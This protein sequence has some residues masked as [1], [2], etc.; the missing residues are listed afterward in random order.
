MGKIH[1]L[2]SF[3]I[4]YKSS[5]EDF[6]E[7]FSKVPGMVVKWEE[8]YASLQIQMESRLKAYNGQFRVRHITVGTP[9]Y[10]LYGPSHVLVV[11]NS[12]SPK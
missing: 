4:S 9:L 3:T 7:L 8:D 10:A 11:R 2:M 5:D 1:V 12:L 6:T